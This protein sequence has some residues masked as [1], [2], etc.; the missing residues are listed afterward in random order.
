[1]PYCPECGEEVEEGTRF[2]P[3]C[4]ARIS[5]EGPRK[6]KTKR[7]TEL[8]LEE[9]VEGALAYLLGFVSGII[10]YF[11]EEENDFIRFHAFQSTVIFLGLAIVGGILSVTLF[12]V[13]ILGT[14]VRILI[15][16]AGFVVWI[17]G[18]IKA[19]RGELYKF[20]V[21]GDMAE[22]HIKG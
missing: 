16:L 17:V 18:M 15:G 19:Y 14:I 8:G 1:M 5:G 2:C 21:A 10:L 12:F 7:N 20:P 9:N 4:G 11:V 22:N 13:P 3:E 6:K